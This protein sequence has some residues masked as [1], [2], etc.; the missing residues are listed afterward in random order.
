VARRVRRAFCK[1]RR[2]LIEQVECRGT[3]FISDRIFLKAQKIGKWAVERS[4]F[5]TS[6]ESRL[7]AQS[8]AKSVTNLFTLLSVLWAVFL[9]VLR[10]LDLF[11]VGLIGA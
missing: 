1:S 6:Y 4:G 9:C 11:D 3:R 10:I 2:N 8:H 7:A 5:I